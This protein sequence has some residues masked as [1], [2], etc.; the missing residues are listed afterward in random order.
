VRHKL[1]AVGS[2]IIAIG[3]KF[4]GGDPEMREERR[5][6]RGGIGENILVVVFASPLSE[7]LAPL[8]DTNVHEVSMQALPEVFGPDELLSVQPASMAREVGD[9]VAAK[10]CHP[11]DSF[12]G[13]HSVPRLL[14]QLARGSGAASLR[15]F[16]GLG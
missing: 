12:A 6:E 14:K 7:E 2:Y 8:K 5:L 3:L 1:I 11:A 4:I 10:D 13:R 16:L 9:G 15:L